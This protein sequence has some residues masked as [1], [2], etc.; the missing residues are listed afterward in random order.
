M[1]CICQTNSINSVTTLCCLHGRF[2]FIFPVFTFH[3][4]SPNKLLYTQDVK[5][6]E[7]LVF[8]L[9]Q[10]TMRVALFLFLYF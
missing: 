10:V 3:A 2:S 5:G 4:Y 7:E 6:P 1:G 9:K 8:L